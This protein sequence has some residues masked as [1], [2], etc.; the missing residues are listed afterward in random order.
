MLALREGDWKT[1]SEICLEEFED[2]HR[3]FE[4]SEPAFSYRSSA[5]R[6]VVEMVS[7]LWRDQGDGPAPTMDAG[8]NVH[9]IWRPDQIDQARAFAASV[10][11]TCSVLSSPGLR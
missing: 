3:L 1:T 5:S 7:D 8:A 10:S 2:M 9:L 4:T 11:E 6:E